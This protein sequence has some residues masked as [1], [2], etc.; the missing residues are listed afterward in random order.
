MDTRCALCRSRFELV[1]SYTRSQDTWHQV[2]TPCMATSTDAPPCVLPNSGLHSHLW[3]ALRRQVYAW[4]AD[5]RSQVLQRR[6]RGDRT[7]LTQDTTPALVS[8]SEVRPPSHAAPF[9]VRPAAGLGA[10]T[11]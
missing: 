8:A 11:R 9:A 2:H 10:E 7:H 1:F 4:V 5:Q 6:A 3:P